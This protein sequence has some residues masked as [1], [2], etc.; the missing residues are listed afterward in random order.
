MINDVA[1]TEPTRAK[2]NG[3]EIVYDTFG[4]T[5]SAPLL[6]I[7]GLGGQMI[8]WEEEFCAQLA[9]RGY[10][11]IR[12]DNRDIGLSTKI[13]EA[14]RVDIKALMQAYRRHTSFEAPYLLSAMAADTVGLLDALDIDVAHIVGMSMGGMIAQT[15][16]I[17]TPQR[18]RTL[19]SIM[20]ST[21][22]ASLPR[23]TDEA[24][25]VLGARP[26]KDRAGYAEYSVDIWRVLNGLEIPIDEAHVREQA[27]RLY[28]RGLS[29]AGFGRQLAA[30]TASGSRKDALGSVDV[31]S[32]VIH[33]DIDPL[34][35]I[36]CGLDTFESIPGAKKLIVKGMGHYLHPAL[37]SQ[38][39]DAIA[40]HA[41]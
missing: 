37:W 28:D 25:S 38:L 35:R 40:R 27:K 30:I 20:S 9:S 11:V 32:L 23:A 29:T 33:G 1:H 5:T 24:F 18:V 21:G 41:I 19:T 10:W 2:A 26:P 31:P 8:E 7:M 3:I 34:V 4:D 15:L 36:E 13:D 16:T 39:I 12:F 6:L 22:D 14:G 17:N